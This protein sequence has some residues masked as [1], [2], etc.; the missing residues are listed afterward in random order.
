LKQLTGYIF[1]IVVFLNLSL[2]A[3]TNVALSKPVTVS[4]VQSGNIA[5]NAVDGNTSTRW[6]ASSGSAPQWLMVDLGG[7]YSI[8]R[9][10]V[11]WEM[12]AAY[13]YKIET[14]SDNSTWTQRVD[15]T[16][17][18]TSQQTFIDNFSVTA[19]YV[20]ITATGL[21]SGSWASIFEFR[22]F[23]TS[24]TTA[25]SITTQPANL[26]VTEGQSAIF[27]IAATGN[28]APGYQWRRNGTNISG[29]TSTSYTIN[30]A[31]M[32]DSG[33]VFSCVVS[34][35]AGSVTSSNAVLTVQR[36][37]RR[38]DSLALVAFY[39]ST[40][41]PN[42][43]NKTNWL[44]A[45][46][47]NTWYGV[48]VD[49]D[50]VSNTG[51]VA[52]IDLQSNNLSGPLPNEIGNLT[53]MYVLT[54]RYSNLTGSIPATIGNCKRL[55]YLDLYN[56]QLS[57]SIPSEIRQLTNLESFQVL[58]NRL[59]GVIPPEVGNLTKMR[60]FDVSNNQLSGTIPSEFGNLINIEYLGLA[61]NQFDGAIPSGI[62]NFHKL[63]GLMLHSNRFTD[64]PNSITTITGD[65]SCA[66]GNNRFC[67]LS[68]SV[69]SWATANDP[70]WASTQ[71]C[72]KPEVQITATPV[73][74]QPPLTVAFTASNIG[75]SSIDTWSWNFGDGGTASLQNPSHT[76]TSAGTFVA[77]LIGTGIGGSDTV[78]VSIQ[79]T[80]P[81]V[82]ITQPASQTLNQG[83]TITFSVEVSGA[84]PLSYQWYKNGS[85]ISGATSSIYTKSNVQQVDTGSYTVRISN[86]W[87]SAT[88]NVARLQVIV[89]PTIISNP[90][91]QTVYPGASVTFSVVA[92]GTSPLTYHWSKNWIGIPGA[93][94]TSY[95][96][97]LVQLADTG[98]YNV[99]VSNRAGTASSNI[100][101]LIVINPTLRR[102][103]SLALVAIY[104]STGGPNWTNKTNWLTAQPIDTWF[105]VTVV[106]GRVD[107]IRFS[108][109]NG[110]TGSLPNDISNL[111]ALKSL[112]IA[113]NHGLQ[114]PI[115]A[116]IGNMT[117]LEYLDL[118]YNNLSG[119]IPNELINLKN[120]I[121]L[122]LTKNN[123]SDTIPYCLGSLPNL[124]ILDLTA[125]RLV[126]SIPPTLTGLTKLRYLGLGSN[127]ISGQI[128]SEIGEIKT[129]VALDLQWN[130]LSGPVPSNFG[131]LT[132]LT[133]LALNNN[134]LTDLPDSIANLTILC[135]L[136]YN[137][138]CNLSPVATSWANAH[139]SDWASTQTCTKP[140][141]QI[142]AT[143]ISGPPPLTVAFTAT[144]TGSTMIENW[145]WSFGDG[146]TA[147]IQ[148]PSHVYARGGIFNACLIAKGIG[149]SGYDTAVVPIQVDTPPSITTQPA[150]QSVQQGADVTFSVVATGTA[151]LSYQW[152]KNGVIISEAIS[153][154][155]LITNVQPA[156]SGNYSVVVRND[157]GSVNSS[158][159]HLTVTPIPQPPV[160]TRDPISQIVSLGG[161]V[162]FSVTATGTQPFSYVWQKNGIVV[163][164]NTST[165]TISPVSFDD[166]GSYR[167][168]VSNSLGSDT[169]GSAKLTV[170]S[171]SLRPTNQLVSIRGMLYDT[172]GT[173]LGD[174]AIDTIEATV[175]LYD[176]LNGGALQYTEFFRKADQHQITVTKGAFTVVLG[177][178]TTTDNLFSVCGR[179]ANLW[180]EITVDGS[181]PDVL[182]PRLPL[183]ASPV[184]LSRSRNE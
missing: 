153:D 46:P 95:A 163:G 5:S 62:G 104:N 106:G 84:A 128:P 123:L 75:S 158:M 151:P 131:N 140:D 2:S 73:S 157:A 142:I 116:G 18:T 79:V 13:K 8:S 68:P 183:T 169:S 146:G 126:G 50:P 136:G 27:N 108:E 43:V 168:I 133:S 28:P 71:T 111:S 102:Q 141:I 67:N 32:T 101:Q 19:R 112:I 115:P 179:N 31:A 119:P 25:P 178:G 159:A 61:I 35:S 38:Q 120:L 12:T 181:S 154:S 161:R 132:N 42:W 164:G 121:S 125:N 143:P 70:D 16:A 118:I 21:P 17:N 1:L 103:D 166:S 89:P 7:S 78:S 165:L 94:D 110:L 122:M 51:R 39:N 107:E 72:T 135:G 6:C 148:N 9:T 149:N 147:T 83:S 40:G 22:V 69:V 182:Q 113:Y 66:L 60:F 171:D 175:R 174:S 137:Q 170:V 177:Q 3:Q 49:I 29:A 173:P 59:T 52:G 92:S 37:L 82:I 11:M 57:G 81:P 134:L 130:Q 76:Y 156:D 150:S 88:S 45:Q 20:R 167:V 93:T 152:Y 180:V 33:V 63:Y 65:F 138:F 10:E 48:L 85:I 86:S 105:G 162:N 55:Q 36:N 53:Y 144:N 184:S 97:P 64:L 87:G 77:R 15:R 14:S 44:T 23:G 127:L 30:S 24:A 54:I 98:V 100:A 129:L 80:D 109:E 160:I 172:S 4:T 47:I 34:N 56:N 145:N 117:A 124:D 26:T 91:S 155:Y 41:G 74:G 96:I 99:V 90:V 139:D 58:N 176:S 114:G